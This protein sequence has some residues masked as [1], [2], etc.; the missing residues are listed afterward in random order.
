M[1]IICIK[2]IDSVICLCNCDLNFGSFGIYKSLNQ[3]L[4]MMLLFHDLRCQ[5]VLDL[6]KTTVG[7]ATWIRDTILQNGKY[8]SL[9]QFFQGGGGG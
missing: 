8:S 7:S 1:I 2:N 6:K 3:K 5:S 4:Y 9:L